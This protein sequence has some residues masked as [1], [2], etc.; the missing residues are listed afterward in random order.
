MYELGWQIIC[1]SRGFPNEDRGS[2]LAQ[3]PLSAYDLQEGQRPRAP[4]L[5]LFG[6]HCL[7]PLNWICLETL[8]FGDEFC[9]TELPL[10]KITRIQI[11]L[12]SF[13]HHP[14]GLKT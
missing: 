9:N 3:Q 6:K 1:L 10:G 13:Y 7:D 8:L 5:F 14:H 2:S 12:H 4:L 11:S